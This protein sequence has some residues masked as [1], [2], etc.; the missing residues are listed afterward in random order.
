MLSNMQLRILLFLIGCM[1]TRFALTAFSAYASDD[2]L[3]ILGYIA[4]IP[5]IGW[6]YIMFISPRDTGAE[7]FGGKIW[8]QGLRPIHT[9]LWA[10][11]SYLAINEN[12]SAWKVLLVDTLIGLVSF[13]KHHYSA[14]DFS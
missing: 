12:R 14:G 1:G 4:L 2:L 3:K 11:F 7:V 13:L 9:A 5:V 6:L 8:W 10:T